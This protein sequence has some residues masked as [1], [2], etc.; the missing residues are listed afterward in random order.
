GFA[1]TGECVKYKKCTNKGGIC[2]ESCGDDETEIPKAC[3]GEGCKCC[4][5]TKCKISGK[6]RKREGYCVSDPNDC[7]GILGKGCRRNGCQCCVCPTSQTQVLLYSRLSWGQMRGNVTF[8]WTGPNNNVMVK[9]NIEA[10]GYELEAEPEEV[11]WAIYDLPVR[12]D[13]NKRCDIID[14]GTKKENLS[15]MFGKLTM[16]TDGSIVF[17]TTDLS[18][19]G[20]DSIWGHS[21][22]LSGKMVACSNIEGVSGE[23]TYEARFFSPV[24]GSIWIRTWNWNLWLTGGVA[25]TTGVQSTILTD[26]YNTA[27]DNPVSSDHN[28]ALHITDDQESHK[29]CNFLG[30]VYLNLTHDHGRLR[31]GSKRSPLSKNFYSDVTLT[32]PDISGNK[33]LYIVVK[34]QLDEDST[35]ACSKVREINPK[36][37]RA[38]FSSDG[39]SGSIFIKQTSLFS[40]SDLTLDL[41]GLRSNAGGFHVHVLPAGPKIKPWDNPCLATA[42]HYKPYNIDSS[43]SPPPGQGSHDEYELGDLS[44]KHGSLQ[45]F[46]EIQTTLTDYNLPLFGPR[47]VTGRS[48]VI[49]QEMGDRWVCANLHSD[50]PMIRSA[51][52]FRYPVV[53]EIIFEQPENDPLSETMV[54]IPSLVYSDGSHDDTG[55]HRW[56]V[57]EDIPGNDIYNGNMRCVSAGKHYNPYIV[58]LN[59]KVYGDCNSENSARCEVGDLVTRMGKLNVA[60]TI[61]NGATTARFFTDTNLPLT[62]PHSIQGHSIV[63]HDDFAPIHQ[64]DRLA[65]S[66]IFRKFRHTGMVNKWTATPD[67]SLNNEVQ[68]KIEFI[69][70]SMFDVTK[71]NVDIQGLQSIAKGWHV[72]MVPVEHDLEFPCAAS[73]VYGHYN[74]LNVSSANSP[75]PDIGTDDLYE[76]GDLAGKYGTFENKELVRD[77]YNDT[78]LPLFGQ[79]SIIG[80]SIVIHKEENN[81]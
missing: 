11:D 20:K 76:I 52:T 6:C 68:G 77:F 2:K 58:S 36:T 30:V 4:A 49:H 41:N 63:I 10:A 34:H 15:G 64:G 48:I 54:Y 50:L 37:A 43:T 26:L 66:R 40:P 61:S 51:V 62:G 3:G 47:S 70:E 7:I 24:G 67:S 33:Q 25:E 28:W 38:V 74:P 18:L 35:Y 56:H 72:H 71:V 65:C 23:R 12:Y 80:R 45:S 9:V 17:H 59:Q 44:G 69:Q 1:D 22:R 27:D 21:L 39:V 53:G 81:A 73:T 42:G 55:E 57:H 75:P 13:T 60:G 29:G 46:D 5:P 79:T 78:N 32:M 16:P 8:S 14:L 31:I 19:I